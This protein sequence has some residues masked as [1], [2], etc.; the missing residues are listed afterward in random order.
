M[1]KYVYVYL[2]VSMYVIIS[3]CYKRPFARL[4]SPNRCCMLCCLLCCV[5]YSYGKGNNNDYDEVLPKI[6]NIKLLLL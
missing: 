2:C 1:R 3:S 6:Y 4:P 5:V